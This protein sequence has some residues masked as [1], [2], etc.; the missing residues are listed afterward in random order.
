LEGI[1]SIAQFSHTPGE[2]TAGN[3]RQIFRSNAVVTAAQSEIGS[4]QRS[5]FDFD[6]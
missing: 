1:Y 5:R 3:D 6:Q 2:L 4:V